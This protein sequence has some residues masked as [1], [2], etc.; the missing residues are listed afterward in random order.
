MGNTSKQN[1]KERFA[2]ML[3][4]FV[5]KNKTSTQARAA[6]RRVDKRKKFK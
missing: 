2:K 1:K 3:E 5:G 4:G 6:N